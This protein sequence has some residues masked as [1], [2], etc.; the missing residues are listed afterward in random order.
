MSFR[1]TTVIA[2]ALT[3]N[4]MAGDTLLNEA[5]RA[6][7]SPFPHAK[8][9]GIAKGFSVDPANRNSVLSFYFSTYLPGNDI[10]SGWNGDTSNCTAGATSAAYLQATADRINFYRAMAGLPANVQLDATLNARC[11]EAALMM[12]AENSLSHSPPTT[13]S[14]FTDDGALAAGRSNLALG[15]AGP[16]AI[17]A[18]MM[19]GGGNNAAAGHRRWILF[20]GQTVMGSGSVSGNGARDANA[21]W[22]INGG[23]NSGV[24][25]PASWPP[26][27]FIVKSLLV[28]RWSYSHPGADFSNATVRMFENGVEQTLTLNPIANG[29]GDNT[30]VW[31]PSI[32]SP[33]SGADVVYRVEISGVRVGGADV[34]VSYEVTAIDA[35]DPGPDATEGEGEG[36][37]GSEGEGEGEG[38][39]GVVIV[40]GCNP[41]KADA[42]KSM[43]QDTFGDLFTLLLAA[44][45]LAG[46]RKM[47]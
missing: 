28:S 13:W 22:V 37:N 10:A 40:N 29:F 7:D 47:M 16:R 41:S 45:V 31:E 5:P 14:C 32:G 19:D 9:S 24:S 20:P 1:L 26:M 46:W 18:Y 44:M 30:L 43:V 25:Q 8:S 33:A 42:V 3:M 15:N 2:F 12:S 4:A 34:P 17:D 27:G 23:S 36:E 39:G 38:E 11:Q 21:L 35:V 6:D